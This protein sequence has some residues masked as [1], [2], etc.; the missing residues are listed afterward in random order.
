MIG[1]SN[2]LR[3][4]HTLVIA[5]FV[6]LSCNLD[7]L[8]QTDSRPNIVWIIAEDISSHF[9]YQGEELVQT[10]HVDKLAAEGA[11]FENAY[12][13]S[14]VC[15]PCRSALVTGMY[16]TTIGAH[17]H[18]SSRGVE[19]IYL[20]DYVT[21]IPKLFQKAGYYTSNCNGIHWNRN[22]KTDY[23]FVFAF[24]DYYSG[25]DWSGRQP[26]QPFFAQIQLHGGK[27][28]HG[29]KTWVNDRDKIPQPVM[30]YQVTLPPY[31]PDHPAIRQD[32]ADYLN[33][34]QLTDW[35]IGQVIQ[36]LKEDGVLDNTIIFFITDHGLSHA[37]GKQF[38]YDEGAR[39]PFIVWAPGRIKPQVRKDM[40][41]HIDMAATSL[42]FAG[43]DIPDFLESR[44][45][46]GADSRPREYVVTARDRCDETVDHIR[47]IRQGP[48]K[49][50]RNFLPERPYL[51]PNAYKDNKPVMR[52]IRELDAANRLYPVEEIV[53]RKSRLA[54]ELY[55][56]SNDP[57][58][59]NNLAG[60]PDYKTRLTELRTMLDKWIE[61][62]GDQGRTTEPLD[63]YDSDMAAYLKGM[64]KKS[65][66]YQEIFRNIEL[67]KQWRAEGK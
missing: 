7:L 53:T 4:F 29:N 30:P 64:N 26:G 32:W 45:L 48:Y 3:F 10:P 51:Q 11:V 36:R 55:D 18:R 33:T 41:V 58:E 31:Y 43:I 21:P 60:D 13:T 22:G 63:M 37:R 25:S 8:A 12:V 46:F 44:P 38:L 62:T 1:K 59:L 9:N 15:S 27:S 5:L 49:Y 50:I 39:I 67:M 57:W 23:N 28:R 14:P 42:Y 6:L 17:N 40:I 61:E 47:S 34:V 19:K 52:T 54:E 66:R 16:Q 56:L 20:P 2:R 35:E 65:E 24:K